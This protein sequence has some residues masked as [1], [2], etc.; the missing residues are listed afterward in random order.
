[1]NYR[2]YIALY[3]FRICAP[4]FADVCQVCRASV[5]HKIP[6]FTRN[7][8]PQ[9]GSRGILSRPT[10]TLAARCRNI[11]IKP[12]FLGR[13]WEPFTRSGIRNRP[14]TGSCTNLSSIESEKSETSRRRASGKEIAK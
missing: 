3:C 14:W 11:P 12:A 5:Q 8:G 13:L 7:R 10:W 4:F 2:P 6:G 9:C 1:M